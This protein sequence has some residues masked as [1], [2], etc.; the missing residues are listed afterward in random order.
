MKI[1]IS[2]LVLGIIICIHELGHFLAARL[3]KI[4]VDEFSIGMGTEVY[5]Y[6]GEKTKYSFRAIPIGGFVNIKGMEVG[7]ETPD[8][9]NKK[10]PIARFV[11]LFAGVFMN[12][13]LAYFLIFTLVLSMGQVKISEEPIVG[14]IVENNQITSPLQKGDKIIK[15]SNEPVVV[16][17]D[18]KKIIDDFDNKTENKE[19]LISRDGK[20]K[21]VTTTLYKNEENGRYYLGITP[22]LQ[23]IRHGLGESF[24]LAAKDFKGMF[25]Q[26]L[27]SFKLII[28][29]KVQKDEIS[30][31]IGIINIVGEA[32]EMGLPSLMWLMALLSI[33]IGIF[34]LL[35]FPA[36]D[37][38]RI[39]FVILEM[40]GIR[41]NKKLEE[42]IHYGGIIIILGLI[43]FITTNDFFNLGNN[44]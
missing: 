42:R 35:P 6:E 1:L 14:D 44:I 24:V 41:V 4:P 17:E 34:N 11:V 2:L 30:G 26:I 37:G 21:L 28:N 20:E 38:G 31:P 29:G 19:L 13:L 32:S 22:E 33:N 3:F 27:F 25:E 18:I 9:F 15:I 12:F 23:V 39:V 16:W 10:P 36:L 5:S 7:D 8:G 40:L 43:I